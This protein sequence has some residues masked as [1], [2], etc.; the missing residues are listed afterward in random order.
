MRSDYTTKSGC[1]QGVHP[2]SGICKPSQIPL[3]KWCHRK[4]MT[5]LKNGVNLRKQIAMCFMFCMLLT[6]RPPNAHLTWM[7]FPFGRKLLEVPEMCTCSMGVLRWCRPASHGWGIRTSWVFADVRAGDHVSGSS[8][9]EWGQLCPP[10]NKDWFMHMWDK[11]RSTQC[12]NAIPHEC[13]KI[14]DKP[15]QKHYMYEERFWPAAV[16]Q[17]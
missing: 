7:F 12:S 2:A 1:S 11:G 14:D 15:S 6:E 13:Y 3:S 17:E 8:L 16:C 5:G 9:K 10:M 4:G